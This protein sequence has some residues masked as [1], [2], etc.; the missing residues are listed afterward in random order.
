MPAARR[1][2]PKDR[3]PVPIPNPRAL[4]DEQRDVA[5]APDGPLL[6]LAGPGSGKTR[7]LVARIVHLVRDRGVPP[8][9]V[10]ALTFSTRAAQELRT[11]L[12][13]E[14]AAARQVEVSTFHGLGLRIVRHWHGLLGLPSPPR[15]C[16]PDERL[17]LIGSAARG[18]GL[19]PAEPGF[20]LT[21]VDRHR[22]GAG[23]LDA[24]TLAALAAAYERALHSAG[25]V[26]Y[27]AMLLLP[28]R[29][30][31]EYPASL[32]VLQLAYRHVLV[33]ELQDVCCAQYLLARQLAAMHGNL[34]AVGDPDQRIYGWRGADGRALGA[35]AA[36]M[37]TARLAA[38]SQNFRSTGRIVGLAEALRRRR[39][40]MPSLWTAN[41]PGPAPVLRVVAD[42]RAEAE[43]VA[44]EA[45]R[46][47]AEGVVRRPGDVAVLSRTRAQGALLRRAL[48]R[49]GLASA[50]TGREDLPDSAAPGHVRV[51]TA[52]AAKGSEWPVVF[53]TGLE[54]DL[55][56]HARTLEGASDAAVDD[57]RRVL[58]VAVTRA[59]SRLYLSA[60][61]ARSPAGHPDG[62]GASAPPVAARPSRFVLEL[63]DAGVRFDA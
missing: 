17:A 10:L 48:I 39:D 19:D 43:L 1:H 60:C 32:R 46:L 23:A 44:A 57:E 22:L 26:D 27:P 42:D 36:D 41:P 12:G 61:R 35:F 45:G 30:F 50:G 53:V 63:L 47:L 7:L 18:V 14:C 3:G 34:T 25:R 37:P 52:H 31:R 20:L 40:G 2:A 58:Y 29:L 11:R 55:W 9:R 21:Q 51:L 56:P 33:D 15:V 49:A 59:R 54:E 4:T 16:T 38:L 13:A 8:A 62:E 24:D 6:V 28:L 5:F